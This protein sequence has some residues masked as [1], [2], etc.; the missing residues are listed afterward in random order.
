MPS[1]LRVILLFLGFAG[2]GLPSLAWGQ[3]ATGSENGASQ[4]AIPSSGD[5][6]LNDPNYLAARQNA[7]PLTPAMINDLKNRYDAI[8]Q[9]ETGEDDSSMIASP[10]IRSINVSL[11]PGGVTSII[12]TVPGYPTA[13]SF[14][15]ATGE[16]WPIAWDTN[17][18][19][20]KGGDGGGT[21]A[22]DALGLDAT[23]PV[24]GSNV[25]Q[26][27]PRTPYLRGGILVTLQ[28]APKPLAFMVV[29]GKGEY[30][31]DVDRGPNAKES[32]MAPLDI[33][34]TGSPDLTAMLDGVPPAQAVPLSVEGVPPDDLMAWQMGDKDYI[35]TRYMLLSPQWVDSEDGEDGTT[36]Y[37][38]PS[39]PVILLSAD[40]RTVSA[41]LEEN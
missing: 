10:T 9:A 26:L 15:D 19:P 18:I 36:I 24:K 17:G 11:G 21:P 8:Q 39:T 4:A 33:P 22:V 25:L 37:A 23:V 29:S 41:R 32:I 30:D 2:L 28:G 7:I 31:A 5:S 35:R 20:D 27:Q 13:I 14:L 38:V 16:P 40:G 3:T 6:E 34:E 1:S 12:Q